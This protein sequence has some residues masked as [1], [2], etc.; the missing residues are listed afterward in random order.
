MPPSPEINVA[1]TIAR[2]SGFFGGGGGDG[3]DG[4]VPLQLAG[5]LLNQIE[6]GV[7]ACDG[8]GKILFAN[9][10]ARR[11][12]T[13]GSLLAET[14]NTLRCVAAG[15]PEFKQALHDAA[16]RR[17][18]RLLHLQGE[19]DRVMVAV[20]PVS[21]GQLGDR[22][23][24]VMTGRRTPCSALGLEMLALRQGL[25]LAETRVLGALLTN[26]SP[27]DIATARGV[28]LATV[29]TQI[30]SIRNKFGV[31]SIDALLLHAAEVPPIS[32]WH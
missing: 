4:S 21:A 28:G 14:E 2:A 10:A 23:A 22:T 8:A 32:S 24:L 15:A 6:C 18:T 25:T 16:D 19:H 11:E 27:R 12:L 20:M 31:R 7:I 26:T 5:A 29:R 3:G 17:R 13:A 9:R 30:Q 1:A